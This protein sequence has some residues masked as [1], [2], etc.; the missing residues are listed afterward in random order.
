MMGGS[1]EFEQGQK[2]TCIYTQV[3]VTSVIVEG[4]LKPSQVILF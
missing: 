1:E 3:M 4:D 2:I